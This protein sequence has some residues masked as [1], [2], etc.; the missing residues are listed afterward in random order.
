[1]R[2]P[3]SPYFA[4]IPLAAVFNADRAALDGGLSPRTM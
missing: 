2:I 4:P 3:P 1:M